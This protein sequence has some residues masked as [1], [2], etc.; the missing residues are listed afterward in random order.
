[1]FLE[2]QMDADVRTNSFKQRRRKVAKSVERIV[3]YI[4]FGRVEGGEI[5]KHLCYLPYLLFKNGLLVWVWL[6]G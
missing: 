2:S 3:Y 6:E 1:M 4:V 5:R